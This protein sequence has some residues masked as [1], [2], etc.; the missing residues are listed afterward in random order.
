MLIVIIINIYIKKNKIYNN[1]E[2]YFKETKVRFLSNYLFEKNSRYAMNS[3]EQ[4]CNYFLEPNMY[5]KKVEKE[6]PADICIIDIYFDVNDNDIRENEYNILISI[7]NIPYWKDILNNYKFINKYG[8]ENKKINLYYYNHISN[9]QLNKYNQPVIPT[10]YAYIREYL[11][12]SKKINFEKIPFEK[13]KNILVINKSKLNNDINDFIKKI[14]E[15]QIKLNYI[16]EHNDEIQFTSCYHS[17]ELLKVF[18]KYKCILCIENS[19]QDGYITEKIF[20]CFLANSIPLYIGAPNINNF[21]NEKS[22]ID[23]RSND[24]INKFSNIINSYD[25]FLNMINENKI[26]NTFT[27]EKL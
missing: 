19:Y 22:Y 4:F 14:E 2:K 11:N 24:W 26:I 10:I 8:Y 6:E 3:F 15:Q 7:E 27:F 13:K 18:N 25:S 21:I 23:L 16:D 5:Y 20:N 12:E 9:F 17:I 1:S